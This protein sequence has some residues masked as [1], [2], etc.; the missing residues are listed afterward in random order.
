[1]T[2]SDMRIDVTNHGLK[3]IRHRLG[4]CEAREA[5]EIARKVFERGEDIPDVWQV[6]KPRKDCCYYRDGAF[7]FIF[8]PGKD[9]SFYSYDTRY[10]VTVVGPF[11]DGRKWE[12]G[13]R[14]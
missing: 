10:L 1:M 8:A 13:T 2:K 7:V 3:A 6:P 12:P 4:P 14:T 5:R 11:G 9:R